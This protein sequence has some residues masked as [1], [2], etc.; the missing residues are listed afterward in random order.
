LP[1]G[2]PYLATS[3]IS[4][5]NKVNTRYNGQF[6]NKG[7]SP[8]PVGKYSKL[9]KKS[10]SRRLQANKGKSSLEAESLGVLGPLHSSQSKK[11]LSA[12]K[13]RKTNCS[14][15]KENVKWIEDSV[16]GETVVAKK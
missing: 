1:P 10:T 16:D 3:N 11:N 15:N 7:L 8:L 4:P 14:C 6:S 12:E 2:G 5:N 9:T 13:R